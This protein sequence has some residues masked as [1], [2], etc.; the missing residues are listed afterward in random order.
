MFYGE[1][2]THHGVANA[3]YTAV[4]NLGARDFAVGDSSIAVFNE[5]AGTL[6]IGANGAGYWF[7]SMGAGI[8]DVQANDYTQCVIG[9]NGTGT[10]RGTVISSYSRG[11]NSGGANQIVNANTSC[12][13]NLSANDV[14]RFYVYHNEGTNENT[15][16]N[17]SFA[18]GY[19]IT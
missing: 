19:K 3:V 18:M 7:L 9:K 4:V 17:R 12:M 10:D 5:D 13:V 8:D 11:W 2:D 6:T 14:V 15:E 16:P 1:Q